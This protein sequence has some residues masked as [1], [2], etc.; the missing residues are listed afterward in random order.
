MPSRERV[1]ALLQFECAVSKYRAMHFAQ[2]MIA[3]RLT[4]WIISRYYMSWND[5]FLG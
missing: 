1:T 5:D 3:L 4:V 2:K